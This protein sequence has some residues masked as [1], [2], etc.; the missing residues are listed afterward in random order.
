MRTTKQLL[1]KNL[2]KYYFNNF[3]NSM[4]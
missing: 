1:K 3:E 2:I 4:Q